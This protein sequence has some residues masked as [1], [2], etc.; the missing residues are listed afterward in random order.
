MSDKHEDANLILKLYDFRREETMR[1]ARNWFFAEF[2]PTSLEDFKST[3]MGENSA[4]YRMVT[5]Y[6]EMAASLVNNGAIDAKMFGDANGE[7]VGVFLKLEPFLADL[8][9]AFNMPNYLQHLEQCVL[10]APGAEENLP[11]TRERMK[12]FAAAMDEANKA[13][14]GKA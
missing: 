3:L 10:N 6:W 7:Q 5:T 8:R 4:Y 13:K 1:K 2:R 12:M 14:A 11:R 9:T